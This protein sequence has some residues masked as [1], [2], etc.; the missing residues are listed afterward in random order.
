VRIVRRPSANPVH[1]RANEKQSDVEASG[2]GAVGD[3]PGNRRFLSFWVSGGLR[4][5]SERPVSET[6]G[7]LCGPSGHPLRSGKGCPGNGHDDLAVC[8]REIGVWSR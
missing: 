5:L 1:T 2:D 7:S 6:V 3:A 8:L 4:F